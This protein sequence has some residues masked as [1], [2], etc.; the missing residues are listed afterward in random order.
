M[1]KRQKQVQP[2][3]VECAYAQM[4]DD[5]DLYAY[6]KNLNDLRLKTAVNQIK[7]LAEDA[8]ASPAQKII[9]IYET[10]NA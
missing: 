3:L 2:E 4:S 6:E 9:A 7:N 8:D 1:F 10:L 5:D